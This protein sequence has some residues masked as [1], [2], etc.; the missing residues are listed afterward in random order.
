LIYEYKG[1]KPPKYG[2]A[3]SKEK[4]EEW[5]KQGRLEFPK[6]P[7][8]RIRRKRFLDELKGKPVQNL[9]DDIEMISAQSAE[10]LGYP[11]QKPEA[12][13]ERIIRA[14]TN[15]G[16]M[17]FDAYCGCGTTIA[18]A[19]RLG[20]NWI[21]I[22]ITYQSISLILKRLE[23]SFG[24]DFTKDIIDKDTKTVKL[25]AKVALQGVPQDIES[26]RALANKQDDRLR[27]EFEKWA[28]LTY[29]NNRA[30]INEKKGADKGIDGTA[31][32]LHN[33]KQA[34][35][36]VVFSVTSGPLT[37][38]QIRDLAGVV[39]RESAAI[40]ILLSLE[41]PT[42]PML[43]EASAAGT[44]QNE[45]TGQTYDKLQIVTIQEVIDG[46]RLSLPLALE[47]LKSAERKKNN[48]NQKSMFD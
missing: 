13:L 38:S 47:V 21:G 46:K 40:G 27:K 32:I 31:F 35:K 15:E 22:D 16:D 19:E 20:R 30:I 3:I 29:S 48:N 36:E 2:W 25:P 44:Y 39:S 37:T 28:I 9:W 12:L 8:G 26:A 33:A 24:R 1:Y 5:D 41:E 18:V 45:L 7:E 4:M 11:T 23:D 34:V 10:R 17:V 43:A 6:N 14:S 42:K